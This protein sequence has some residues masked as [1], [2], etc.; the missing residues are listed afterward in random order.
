MIDNGKAH[1][2]SYSSVAEHPT[3]NRQTVV[4]FHVGRPI[5]DTIYYGMGTIAKFLEELQTYQSNHY[6]YY[7]RDLL[8]Q[9]YKDLPQGIKK[10]IAPSPEKIRKLWRGCDGLS[11]T[12]AVSFTTNNGIAHLF[13]AYVIPFTE[14]ASFAGLIDTE[15]ASKLSKRLGYD[16]SISDDEGEVIAIEIKWHSY[17]EKNLRRYLVA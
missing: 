7:P 1:A 4:R 13:G 14:I 15:K 3:D 9:A 11:E 10:Y 8:V 6:G 17:L 16:F 12:R 5:L 2:T